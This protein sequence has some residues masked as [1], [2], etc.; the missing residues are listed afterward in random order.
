MKKECEIVQ[1]LL[2]GY[3]D[4]I[5]SNSSKELVEEHIKD[6]N[7]CKKILEDIKN[8]S[9]KKTYKKEVDYLKKIKTKMRRK[10]IL[11]T[12][13]TILL[14]I[15]VIFSIVAYINYRNYAQNMEIFL[16]D[17][18]TQE[19]LSDIENTIRNMSDNAEITYISKERALEDLKEKFGE[20]AYLLDGY[21]N[22]DNILPASYVVK[23]NISEIEEI[24]EKLIIKP[25]VKKITTNIDVNPYALL[26]FS[27]KNNI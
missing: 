8:D 11:I 6:C 1:D 14:S 3:N 24:E 22:S 17:D 5:L 25:G 13:T 9:K 26:Y 20:N 21:S 10:S 19:Q 2:F 15:F 18:I 7:E 4:E 16:T 12:I 27:V 23:A